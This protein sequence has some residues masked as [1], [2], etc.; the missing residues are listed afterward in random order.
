MISPKGIADLITL[1]RALLGIFLVWLGFMYGSES[2]PQAVLVMLLCWTGD[3]FDGGIARLNRPFRRSW[4]GDHDLEVDIFVS[5]GLG[6][7]L[8]GAGFIPWTIALAYVMVWAIIIWWF[9]ADKNLLM[10]VQAFI[11]LDF[12]WTAVTINPQTGVWLV[13]WILVI[14][15]LN[16]RRFSTRVVP[17]FIQGMRSVW[18]GHKS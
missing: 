16:W 18:H 10:L 5:L 17:E 9:G 12:I 4:L 6:L 2:L 15:I 13:V 3:L 7:Y 1:I 8:V 11:Y 14:T